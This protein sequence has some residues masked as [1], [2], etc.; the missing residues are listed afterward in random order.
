[1]G[2]HGYFELTH[3]VTKYT[4][5]KFLS[6]VGKRTECFARMSTTMGARESSDLFRDVRGFA[7]KFY[8]EE[9]NFDMVG[10]HVPVFFIRDPMM[11]PDMFHAMKKHPV[12]GYYDFNTMWDFLS[13]VPESLHCTTMIFTDRGVPKDYRHMDGYGAHTFKWVN[14]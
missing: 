13:S 12:K 3:D 10:I 9:G 11:A 5:A 6:Q 4:K 14:A 1:M 7:W 2:A 8:T